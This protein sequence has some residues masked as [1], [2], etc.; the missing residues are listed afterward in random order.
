[1][2]LHCL[3]NCTGSV[4]L[5]GMQWYNGCN[6]YLSP[7]IPCLAVAFDNGRIQIMRHE[8]DESES[9]DG[10]HGYHISTPYVHNY[11]VN[12]AN[13][14]A[15]QPRPPTTILN[16]VDGAYSSPSPC[17]YLSIVLRSSLLLPL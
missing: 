6:G 3:V 14:T 7:N 15:P 10:C 16:G 9:L 2:A 11:P 12:E 17:L 13:F 1:M 4:Q 5:V 8:L